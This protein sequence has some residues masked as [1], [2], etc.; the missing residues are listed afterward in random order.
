MEMDSEV[1]VH[2]RFFWRW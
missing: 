2:I 1:F